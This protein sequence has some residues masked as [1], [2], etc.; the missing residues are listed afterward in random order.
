[1]KVKVLYQ[2]TSQTFTF[3][4]A[5]NAIPYEKG[6]NKLRFDTNIVVLLR[7]LKHLEWYEMLRVAKKTTK[8]ELKLGEVKGVD[9]YNLERKLQRN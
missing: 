3:N 8:K 7:K 9:G 6:S 4:I 1:M 5:S 2:H